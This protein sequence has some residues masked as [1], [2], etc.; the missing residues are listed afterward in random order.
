MVKGKA[1]LAGTSLLE[2]VRSRGRV[3]TQFEGETRTKGSLKDDSDINLI[4]KRFERTGILPQV[5]GGRFEDLQEVDYQT[6]M[7]LTIEAGQAF[8]SLPARMRER[9]GNDPAQLLRFLEDPR[10]RE[11][12]VALG[13]VAKPDEVA[14]PPAGGGEK[15]KENIRDQ[16]A[17]KSV[18][19]A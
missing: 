11:E 1:L 4:M 7:N 10:N 17:D 14:V 12:A 18:D 13:I 15:V 2:R 19:K 8:A 9:F 3:R 6:A 16:V 5:G